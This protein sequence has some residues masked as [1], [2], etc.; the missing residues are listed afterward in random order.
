MRP[1]PAALLAAALLALSFVPQATAAPEPSAA[2]PPQC[3]GTIGGGTS[4]GPVTVF[5]SPPC[6]TVELRM[7]CPL[8]GR[9][10]ERR[11]GH[12]TVRTYTCTSPTDDAASQA[13]FIPPVCLER[14]VRQGPA[15]VGYSS[16]EDERVE[17]AGGCSGGGAQGIHYAKDLG[18]AT[19]RVAYCVPH[20]PPPAATAA[21]IPTPTDIPYCI[22]EDCRPIGE[23]LGSLLAC[24]EKSYT[25]RADTEN[26]VAVHGDCTADLETGKGQMCVGAWYGTEERDVGPVHWTRHYCRFPGGDPTGG[27]GTSSSDP[28][29]CGVQQR[30]PAPVPPCSPIGD[31]V[32]GDV[33]DVDVSPYCRVIVSVDAADC[34][35][36]ERWA[37]QTV[38]PLTVRSTE[39]DDGTDASTVAMADPF[40]TCV[41]E[42]GPGLPDGCD[43]RESTPE[44]VGP[45]PARSLVWGGDCD[46]DVEPIGACAPPSGRTIERRILFVHVTLLLCGGGPDPIGWS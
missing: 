12:V 44:A 6:Y 38:G 28:R 1:L 34:T 39:C 25:V 27:I 24:P 22:L 30:C 33:A 2:A 41:R 9:W 29:P 42:C 15:T 18:P 40:P 10:E 21:G 5:A 13:V 37:S 4:V 19:A 23:A 16:C 17:V 11:V 46:V 36:T 35:G 3:N 20:S 45:V 43:L 8:A 31:P 14:E 26:T 7:S 32:A